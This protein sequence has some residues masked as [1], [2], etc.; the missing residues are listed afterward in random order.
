M[1]KV[2]QTDASTFHRAHEA[3]RQVTLLACVPFVALGGLS[4]C[5][6]TQLCLE[7]LPVAGTYSGTYS[8][9]FI[10]TAG[11]L[12]LCIHAL[13]LSCCWSSAVLLHAGTHQQVACLTLVDSLARHSAGDAACL[14]RLELRL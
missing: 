8:F 1:G 11:W 9:A 12:L 5:R 2:L 7:L 6:A 14:D 4:R 3:L 13:G 10:G